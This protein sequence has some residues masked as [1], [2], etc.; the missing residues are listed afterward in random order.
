MLR[1]LPGYSSGRGI[2]WELTPGSFFY[3]G[4]NI[5]PHRY[6]SIPARFFLE[7]SKK[8]DFSVV[9]PSV[10]PTYGQNGPWQISGGPQKGYNFYWA[11]GLIYGPQLIQWPTEL[12]ITTS[13]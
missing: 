7:I 12:L 5:I 8:N 11:T 6:D 2:I 1:I 13:P 9:Y 4:Q 10:S 3:V